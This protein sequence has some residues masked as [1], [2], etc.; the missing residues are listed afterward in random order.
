MYRET[1]QLE[2]N[3]YKKGQHTFQIQENNREHIWYVYVFSCNEEQFR[4]RKL[5][6]VGLDLDLLMWNNGSHFGEDENLLWG[7][8]IL[9]MVWIGFLVMFMK[10]IIQSLRH[11]KP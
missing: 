7:Y 3:S 10:P 11:D 8:V 1:Y 4:N 9:V 6:Q 5:S 2:L